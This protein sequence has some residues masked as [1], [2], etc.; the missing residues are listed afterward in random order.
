MIGDV[1]DTFDGEALESAVFGRGDDD[2]LLKVWDDSVVSR[3]L[4][5]TWEDWLVWLVERLWATLLGDEDDFRL[6]TVNELSQLDLSCLAELS[7]FLT[8]SVDLTSCWASDNA[9]VSIKAAEDSG[10]F[11]F[12]K[13]VLVIFDTLSTVFDRAFNTCVFANIDLSG[14]VQDLDLVT[15]AS[16]LGLKLGGLLGIGVLLVFVVVEISSLD[17][18][19]FLGGSRF[20]GIGL[21]MEDFDAW[22]SKNLGHLGSEL[23]DLRLWCLRKWGEGD[24]D[25]I[26]ELFD[27]GNLNW[28]VSC[29]DWAPGDVVL[30]DLQRGLEGMEDAG[31]SMLSVGVVTLGD[32]DRVVK[33]LDWGGLLFLLLVTIPFRGKVELLI[34]G[35]DRAAGEEDRAGKDLEELLLRTPCNSFGRD[36]GRFWT[37]ADPFRELESFATTWKII[38][39]FTTY[40]NSDSFIALAIIIWMTNGQ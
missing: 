9:D 40:F 17:F 39:K 28:Y 5:L 36:D 34:G 30:G 1:L 7:E 24:L 26:E 32:S 13:F 37:E 35:R 29:G 38:V 16:I 20:N 21:T 27:V 10:G 4:L 12:G 18:S 22:D 23:V 3:E 19:G 6:S 25:W 15:V 14:V 11:S 8:L 31:L 33:A 2:N